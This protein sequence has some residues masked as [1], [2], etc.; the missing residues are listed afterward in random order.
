MTA[1]DIVH[2][3]CVADD[4]ML[5]HVWRRTFRATPQIARITAHAVRPWCVAFSPTLNVVVTAADVSKVI[6]TFALTFTPLERR[7][8]A[9][10][11]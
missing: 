11:Q 6:Q 8:L 10:A 3:F 4:R 9:P 2:E 1:S 7:H 5:T